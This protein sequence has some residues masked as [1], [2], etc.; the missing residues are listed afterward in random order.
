LLP[1]AFQSGHSAF[2]HFAPM[3]VAQGRLTVNRMQAFA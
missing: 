1:F 2:G 3:A